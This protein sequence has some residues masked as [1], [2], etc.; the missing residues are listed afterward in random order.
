MNW[1]C[2]LNDEITVV[3]LENELSTIRRPSL[4]ELA[5]TRR[6]KI[7]ERVSLS[8]AIFEDE[9]AILEQINELIEK[10]AFIIRV[11][12]TLICNN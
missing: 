2:P 4:W 5:H 11:F 8:L 7:Y 1:D 6:F 9:K 3:K 12:W 10:W